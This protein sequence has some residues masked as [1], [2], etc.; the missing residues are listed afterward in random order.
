[1]WS[2][3][4]IGLEHRKYRRTYELKGFFDWRLDPSSAHI[5]IVDLLEKFSRLDQ[6]E[7]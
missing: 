5:E 3:N 2:K 4:W 1:M 7:K 6:S